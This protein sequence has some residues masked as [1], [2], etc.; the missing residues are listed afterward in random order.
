MSSVALKKEEC[1]KRQETYNVEKE[2]VSEMVILLND[3]AYDR[4]ESVLYRQSEN[5][6]YKVKLHF[7]ENSIDV[8]ENIQKKL[9]ELY[10]Q[11]NKTKMGEIDR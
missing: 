4:K 9:K 2:K 11:N 7:Q 5:E 8:I 10:V 1:P 3:V 6:N